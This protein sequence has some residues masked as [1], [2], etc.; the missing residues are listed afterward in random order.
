MGGSMRQLHAASIAVVFVACGGGTRSGDKFYR[1]VISAQTSNGRVPG[2][3]T[4]L[5]FD[6]ANAAARPHSAPG[7]AT[8]KP[9]FQVNIKLAD[10]TKHTI[11][12]GAVAQ[13]GQMV[14]TQ[15]QWSANIGVS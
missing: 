9:Q 14:V 3:I 11:L 12:G 15:G 5:Q 10:G 4:V 2:S 7:S 8:D 6:P 1:G 13:G